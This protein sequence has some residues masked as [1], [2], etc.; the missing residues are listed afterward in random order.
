MLVKVHLDG[1]PRA[2]STYIQRSKVFLFMNDT[3]R[4]SCIRRLR[5]FKWEIPLHLPPFSPT[6]SS[7][8][9]TIS[10]LQLGRK[11][12]LLS[13]KC[14]AMLGDCTRHHPTCKSTSV[15]AIEAQL[16]DSTALQPLQ[17]RAGGHHFF[18]IFLFT[19]E[20]L[21]LLALLASAHVL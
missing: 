6:L 11:H 21:F 13:L 4:F 16:V 2:Q 20:D 14:F 8:P 12:E 3:M 19:V 18:C 17:A 9:A 15:G 1:L 5:I 10:T 7:R